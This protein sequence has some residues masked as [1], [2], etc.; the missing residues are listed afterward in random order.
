LE[1][2]TLNTQGELETA[3]TSSSCGSTNANKAARLLFVGGRKWPRAFAPF[4]A[5]K[6]KRKEEKRKRNEKK[7]RVVGRR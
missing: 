1:N 3:P 2:S 5:I 4:F 6:E 7:N